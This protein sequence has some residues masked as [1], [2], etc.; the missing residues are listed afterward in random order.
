MREREGGE[1][2]GGGVFP[3]ISIMHLINAIMNGFGKVVS[4]EL[5]KENISPERQL[6]STMDK[7]CTE[8][9][10]KDIERWDCIC[11]VFICQNLRLNVIL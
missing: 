11:A 9:R 7:S 6:E 4:R 8:K 10:M 2:E 1:R 5:G 3:L